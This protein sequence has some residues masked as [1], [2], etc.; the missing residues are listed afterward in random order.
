MHFEILIEDQS[1]KKMLDILVPKII[2]VAQH[3]FTV[4][5]YKGI[6]RI[7][8]NLHKVKD[9]ATRHLLDQLPRLL[10]GYGKTFAAYPDNYSA[11]VIV[12]CDLDDR[13]LKKFKTELLAIAADCH[14]A[15]VACFCIAVEEGEAWFLGDMDAIETAY[16]K[17]R[18]DVLNTYRNDSICGTWEILADAV[19][20]GGAKKLSEGGY[21]TIGHEK[22]S[23]AEKI[24]H[25]MNVEQ[26]KSPSFCY[27]REKLRELTDSQNL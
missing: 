23:W 24:T 25:N 22:S 4:H 10:Q 9:A 1:G 17:Y 18:Q 19:C 11:A 13:C 3:T 16:P 14:P 26:N 8:K 7:P 20:N 2:D 15:P 27:F 5:A 6:G 21:Q 12:V